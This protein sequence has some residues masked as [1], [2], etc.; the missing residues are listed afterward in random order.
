MTERSIGI[1]IRVL[2]VIILGLSI[3]TFLLGGYAYL[4]KKEAESYRLIID[5]IRSNFLPEESEEI[6]AA[7]P[8]TRLSEIS[9]EVVIE[10]PQPVKPERNFYLETFD[11]EQ[12]IL[13]SFDYFMEGTDFSYVVV[14]SDVAFKL[15]VEAGELNYF[16]TRIEDGLYGVASLVGLPLE[17]L[18]PSKIVYGLQLVSHT[19][20]DGLAPQ[21]INLRARGYPAFVYRWTTS[22]GRVFYSAILGLFPDLDT[23]RAYSSNLN[24]AEVE[25]LTGW[26]ISDRFPRRIE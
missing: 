26:R 8:A 21:V 23:V 18:Y 1:V 12:L 2:I 19:L 24:V 16:I 25:E 10:R 22:D 20:A 3:F 6:E 4:L 15:C 9:S 7:I 5:E 14:N 17:G 11:Y 13:R